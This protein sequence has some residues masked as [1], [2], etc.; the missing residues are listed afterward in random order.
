MNTQAPTRVCPA[1][2]TEEIETVTA[3]DLPGRGGM[4]VTACKRKQ[5]EAHLSLLVRH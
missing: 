2:G 4:R 5:P 3:I 1:P